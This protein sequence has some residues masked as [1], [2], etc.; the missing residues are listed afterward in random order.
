MV[1][2][3]LLA[4]CLAF[5]PVPGWASEATGTSARFTLAAPPEAQVIWNL[6][7]RVAA[8]SLI[9]SAVY[10]TPDEFA[11]AVLSESS[12]CRP[13]F[14]WIFQDQTL[15]ESIVPVNLAPS[16]LVLPTVLRYYEPINISRFILQL[17][18]FQS[19]ST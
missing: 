11:V 14:A 17:R 13:E 19:Q 10:P 15:F 7:P 8:L 6:P 12:Q 1:A 18:P 5:S 3:R 2:L 4:F 9:V 16:P